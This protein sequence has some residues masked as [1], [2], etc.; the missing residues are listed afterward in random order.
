[1][2][3]EALNLNIIHLAERDMVVLS[4]MDQVLSGSDMAAGRDLGVTSLPE[5]VTKPGYIR[6]S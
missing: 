2:A 1:V 3:F 4:P 5:R 6:A